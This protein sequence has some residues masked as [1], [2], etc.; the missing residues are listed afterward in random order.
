MMATLSVRKEIVPMNILVPLFK[1]TATPITS[2][3][4]IGS[5][6]AVVARQSTTK[7]MMTATTRILFISSWVVWIRDL[8]CTA[9]P[10]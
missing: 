2:K 10:T 7:I 5:V 8:F 9:I 6:H 1:S 3:N 4:R